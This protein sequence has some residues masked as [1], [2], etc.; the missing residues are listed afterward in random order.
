MRTESEHNCRRRA[1][2]LLEVLLSLGLS[3]LLLAGIGMAID[4]HLRLLQ[5]SRAEVEQAQLARAILRKMADDLRGA[6]QYKS[7]AGASGSGGSSSGALGADPM[8]EGADLGFDLDQETPDRTSGLVDTGSLPT[9]PGIYGNDRELQ[10]DVSRL[11]RVDQLR[12]LLGSDDATAPYTVSDMRTVLYYLGDDALLSAE[13]LS[14]LPEQAGLVR[15]EIDRAEALLALENGEAIQTLGREEPL[16]A[17]VIDLGFRYF[18]GNDWL[19]TWDSTELNG[20]PVAVEITIWLSRQ[21]SSARGL[22]LDLSNPAVPDQGRDEGQPYQLVVHLP[23]AKPTTFGT[24]DESATPE[25]S[26]P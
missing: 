7:S 11:P 1:F 22:G 3:V 26:S 25:E 12:G 5:T 14:S 2:T 24:T 18:D 6:V 8:L 16:A 17:E 20:L 4:L 15:R 13:S 21:G 10:V 9:V 19:D 23:A